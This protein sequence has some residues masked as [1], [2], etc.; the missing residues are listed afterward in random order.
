MSRIVKSLGRFE[1]AAALLS[2]FFVL[3]VRYLKSEQQALEDPAVRGA[4]QI[5]L[6]YIRTHCDSTVTLADLGRRW[7]NFIRAISARNFPV[8]WASRRWP[9]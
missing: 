8:R 3:L 7:R 9:R 4:S 5:V 1:I 6:E 2:A